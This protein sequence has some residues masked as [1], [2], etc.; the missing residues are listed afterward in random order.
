MRHYSLVEP[1]DKD[2]EKYADFIRSVRPDATRAVS[3]VGKDWNDVLNQQQ[4]R[5]RAREPDKGVAK[6][7]VM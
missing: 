7:P 5:A 3:P 2:A 6:L 4:A 1:K